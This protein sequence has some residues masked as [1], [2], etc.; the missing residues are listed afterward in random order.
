[1]SIAE[2]SLMTSEELQRLSLPDKHVEL[3]RGQFKSA[4]AARRGSAP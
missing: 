1:M 2:S 4:H 3:V